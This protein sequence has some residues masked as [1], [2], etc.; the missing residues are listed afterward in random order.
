MAGVVRVRVTFGAKV[1]VQVVRSS[2]YIMEL[3]LT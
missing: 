3:L 2:W 1:S